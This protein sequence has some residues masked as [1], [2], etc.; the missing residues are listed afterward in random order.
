M[1]FGNKGNKQSSSP[2]T[3]QGRANAIDPVVQQQGVFP[4]EAFEHDNPNDRRGPKEDVNLKMKEGWKFY[5]EEITLE[6]LSFVDRELVEGAIIRSQNNEL[7]IINMGGAVNINADEIELRVKA[8]GPDGKQARDAVIRMA[9]DGSG[10]SYIYIDANSIYIGDKDGDPE[11]LDGILSIVTEDV[12]GVPTDKVKISGDLEITSDD[13]NRFVSAGSRGLYVEDSAGDIIHDLPSVDIETGTTYAGHLIQIVGG[14]KATAF[15]YKP[16][17]TSTST[18]HS[19]IQSKQAVILTSDMLGGN[20]NVKAVKLLVTN[21]ISFQ[22]G[23]ANR[24][25]WCSTYVF[26]YDNALLSSN[27]AS[28][29]Q[30]VGSASQNLQSGRHYGP[31]ISAEIIA[32]V[33]KVGNDYI[34]YLA[35]T[36]QITGMTAS[37]LS[38]YP[39]FNCNI[40][41]LYI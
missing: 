30:R 40:L 36:T 23:K 2:L 13:K 11:T 14:I 20:D 3:A 39:F 17:F 34:M 15:E 12:G 38:Y 8:V 10:E 37:N 27:T 9:K 33:V 7:D 6:Q 41:G 32:P 18:T 22:S 4:L 28:W 1:D 26:A 21:F 16:T 31:Q 25:T 19:D 24:D 29:C 35:T 5:V